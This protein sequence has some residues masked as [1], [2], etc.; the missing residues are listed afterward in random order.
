MWTIN[1]LRTGTAPA[2]STT[3][4]AIEGKTLTRQNIWENYEDETEYLTVGDYYTAYP[5]SPKENPSGKMKDAEGK[6]IANSFIVPLPMDKETNAD[7]TP[8]TEHV[9]YSADDERPAAFAAGR[10]S[11]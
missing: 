9:L 3:K 7:G 1:A 4:A 10:S 6:E 5:T 11:F 2:N 8:V